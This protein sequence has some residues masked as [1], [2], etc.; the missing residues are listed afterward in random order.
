[1][2]SVDLCRDLEVISVASEF[3]GVWFVCDG[4]SFDASGLEGLGTSFSDEVAVFSFFLAFEVGCVLV[5]FCG[6][7]WVKG[8]GGVYEDWCVCVYIWIMNGIVID[9]INMGVKE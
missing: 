2:L 5:G 1:M 3:D 9:L 6:E 8:G 4:G 7:G